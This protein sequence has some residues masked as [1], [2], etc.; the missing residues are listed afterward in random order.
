MLSV[1]ASQIVQKPLEAPKKKRASPK[2]GPAQRLRSIK[3]TDSLDEC[4]D[5]FVDYV[6]MC[7]GHPVWEAVVDFQRPV[8]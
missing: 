4:Q 1:R 8:L 3:S 7:R 6:R 2:L 5:V